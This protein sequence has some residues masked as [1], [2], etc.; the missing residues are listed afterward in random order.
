MELKILEERPNP[1]LK[2]TEYRF[3]VTHG[4]QATPKRDDVRAELAKLVKAP[5]ERVVIERMHAR[6]GT[7]VSIGE[8][9]A[10]QTKE[11]AL[12][13][14]RAHV[15]IRNGLKEKPQKGTPPA[16]EPTPTPA[17]AAAAPKEG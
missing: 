2:R 16:A 12:A 1:L 10:Y 5:K 17:P 15:L 14:A 6:Y 11:A 7:A 9:H 4:T 8:A 3:E 13:T